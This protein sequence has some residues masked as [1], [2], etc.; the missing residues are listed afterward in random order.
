MSHVTDVKLQITD[1]DAL[2]EACQALGLELRRD[3]KTYAWWGAFVG[4]SSAYGEH[5]PA[6]M[7]KCEHAIKVAGTSPRNGSS[8]PWEIGV[9]KA[10]DGN[11]YKLFFDTYGSAGRALADKVGAGADRLRREYA[12]AVAS[13]KAKKELGR[14]GF[15]QTRESLANGGIR[16]RLRRR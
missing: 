5:R 2:D 6:D 11:G 4:D 12:A 3:Q 1:L 15:V 13:K 9:V 7:G 8:G 14:K 16:L 10:K